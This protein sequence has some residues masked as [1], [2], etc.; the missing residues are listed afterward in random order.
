MEQRET[1]EKLNLQVIELCGVLL[2]QLSCVKAHHN[3]RT[4]SDEFVVQLFI[5]HQKIS[6]LIHE[7]LVIEVGYS[8]SIDRAYKAVSC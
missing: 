8:A 7:L 5:S 3:A 2:L 1:V 4:Q 6:T